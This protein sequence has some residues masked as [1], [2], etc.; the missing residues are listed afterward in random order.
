M[1]HGDVH[2][3]H[4]DEGVG[5][6]VAGVWRRD[7]EAALAHGRAGAGVVASVALA[8][9]LASLLGFGTATAH[10]WTFLLRAAALGLVFF[11][12][13]E[14]GESTGAHAS[15]TMAGESIVAS[16]LGST[17]TD[18]RPVVFVDRRVPLH[19]VLADEGLAAVVALELTVAEMVLHVAACILAPLE[20][21]VAGLAVVL[22]EHAV[23]DFA[24]RVLLGD[25][26]VDLVW[27]D[28]GVDEAG[29]DLFTQTVQHCCAWRHAEWIADHE[30]GAVEVVRS[31]CYRLE[32]ESI[33]C[34][35]V[36]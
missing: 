25:V 1:G 19:V 11:A 13:L 24:V 30:V 6:E 5:V 3:G 29:V 33:I 22:F 7:G 31:A 14:A 23:P 21:L 10:V 36:L 12:L 32:E 15:L 28:A 27:W 4:V 2:V 16:E 17:G 9:E 35:A 20:P 18:V 8:V 26:G 34:E